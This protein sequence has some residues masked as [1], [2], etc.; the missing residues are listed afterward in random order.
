MVRSSFTAISPFTYLCSPSGQLSTTTK[1]KPS[2][3]HK[4]K[5]STLQTIYSIFTHLV[6]EKGWM[7]QVR[8][9]SQGLSVWSFDRV[10]VLVNRERMKGGMYKFI[11]QT[12]A[13]RYSKV[14]GLGPL[15]VHASIGGPR[16]VFKGRCPSV[17]ANWKVN[18]HQWCCLRNSFELTI[19]LCVGCR[20]VICC[21]DLG[22]P[23]ASLGWDSE[24]NKSDFV[25]MQQRQRS[26]WKYGQST[27]TCLGDWCSIPSSRQWDSPSPPRGQF[28]INMILPSFSLCWAGTKVKPSLAGSYMTVWCFHTS[29][30]KNL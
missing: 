18:V 1:G 14:D 8:E 24:I 17:C 21:T 29:I 19:I 15:T 9:A 23:N 7:G 28:S 4:D 10:I 27:N 6:T 16:Q 20:M 26:L 11:E 12:K 2:A 30:T 5:C 22:L 25:S 13:G 3:P